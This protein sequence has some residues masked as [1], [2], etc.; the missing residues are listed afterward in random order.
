MAKHPALASTPLT[1]ELSQSLVERIESLR[2]DLGLR[3]ASEVVRLALEKF[4]ADAFE[5]P[6]REQVQISVR[7]VP[8]QKKL[9]FQRAR[10]KRVSA[11]ELVRA[12][13]DQIDAVPASQRGAHKPTRQSRR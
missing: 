10:K 12:A 11:G 7:L 1:F 5:P 2:R 4:D 6:V 13:I 3:S 8:A 9:L